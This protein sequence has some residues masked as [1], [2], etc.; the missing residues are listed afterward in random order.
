MRKSLRINNKTIPGGFKTIRGYDNYYCINPF[1]DIVSPEYID[2]NNK[3]RKMRLLKPTVTKKGYLRVALNKNGKQVR[4]YVHRLVGKAFIPNKDKKPQINH[5]DGNKLNNHIS[6]LEWCTN[7]EN[8]I[9]SYQNGL[10]VGTDATGEKN[11]QAK[12]TE[13]NARSILNSEEKAHYLARKYNVS[14]STIYKIKKGDRWSH[15]N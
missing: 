14:K 5:K 6:N 15:V 7:Q 9:H 12:L 10:R 8:I 1:G 13:E 3:F 2:R 11:T 4:K